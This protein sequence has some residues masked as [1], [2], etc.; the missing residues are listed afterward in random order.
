MVGTPKIAK[1][2]LEF[3]WHWLLHRPGTEVLEHQCMLLLIQDPISIALVREK[4]EN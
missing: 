2:N 4:G 3:E 1:V